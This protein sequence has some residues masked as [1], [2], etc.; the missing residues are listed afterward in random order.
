[1]PEYAFGPGEEKL[2]SAFEMIAGLQRMVCAQK[3][4]ADVDMLVLSS[5]L[6]A[7]PHPSEVFDAWKAMSS[8]FVPTTLLKN[9]AGLDMV[10]IAEQ[11]N[12]RSAFWTEVLQKLV[13]QNE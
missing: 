9:T 11:V 1:M 13:S 7:H 6:N 8:S 2:A 3:A 5:L 12:Q 10:E 4:R